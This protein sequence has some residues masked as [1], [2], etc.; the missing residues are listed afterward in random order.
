MNEAFKVRSD[1]Y[2]YFVRLRLSG[3]TV[4]SIIA[5]RSKEQGASIKQIIAKV[6]HLWHEI[7]LVNNLDLDT[8]FL[9]LDSLLFRFKVLLLPPWALLLLR[10]W[11]RRL[12]WKQ[13][14]FRTNWRIKTNSDNGRSH[15]LSS[16]A[17]FFIWPCGRNFL[18]RIST[19]LDTYIQQKK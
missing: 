6:S 10:L 16:I 8:V 12:T 11:S 1:L 13:F 15:W 3:I 7:F 19:F 4:C 17:R 5:Y 2:N 18:P 14:M 9:S